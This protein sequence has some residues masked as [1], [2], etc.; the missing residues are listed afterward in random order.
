MPGKPMFDVVV[1]RK[2]GEEF[3]GVDWRGEPRTSRSMKIGAI[4]GDRR[5]ETKPSSLTFEEGA[6]KVLLQLGVGEFWVNLHSNAEKPEVSKP[7][8]NVRRPLPPT[9]RKPPPDDGIP[10]P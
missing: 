3:D 6:L 2:D 4:W 5:D 10:F 1:K 7:Q 8:S 9:G